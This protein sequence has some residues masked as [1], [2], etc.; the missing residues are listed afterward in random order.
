MAGKLRNIGLRQMN[1]KALDL[2]DLI[3]STD[4][5]LAMIARVYQGLSE[6]FD[7]SSAA[8]IPINP[9]TYEFEEGYEVNTP[10]GNW[11]KYLNHYVQ[12]DPF[13]LRG[14]EGMNLNK[15]V[16]FSEVVDVQKLWK[17]T[18]FS[19]FMRPFNY[20]HCAANVISCRNLPIAVFSAHRGR[21]ALDFSADE[22]S[23]MDRLGPHIARA[24]YFTELR[25]NK[26]ARDEIG[27]MAFGPDLTAV[28]M[29]D[30]AREILRGISGERVLAALPPKGTGVLDTG[31]WRYRTSVVPLTAASLLIHYEMRDTFKAEALR[32]GQTAQ[33][34]TVVVLEPMQRRKDLLK[35]L[36][37][38]SL[39]PREIDVALL[40]LRGLGNAEIAHTLSRTE[41]TVKDHLQSIFR[42]V[43]VDSRA[44][45][46]AK[47]VG[48]DGEIGTG[49]RRT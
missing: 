29:N 15:T 11:D 5:Q 48:L 36:T 9:A 1:E 32:N 6:C 27:L 20:Y 7:Y 49:N 3:Y 41:T 10:E 22:I 8:F 21:N 38:Y 35:R 43:G 13:V 26:A 33:R 17:S 40:A 16:R 25:E 46:I 24:I 28:F 30:P 31:L 2:I 34:L 47:I 14:P 19:D 12:L 23:L 4:D 42:K 37:R 39:S 45:L 44:A 18:E